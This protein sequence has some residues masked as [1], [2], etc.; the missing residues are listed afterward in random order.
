[1]VGVFSSSA[2]PDEESDGILTVTSP[3]PRSTFMVI[4]ENTLYLVLLW[5]CFKALVFFLQIT[6]PSP[7]TQSRKPQFKDPFLCEVEEVEEIEDAMSIPSNKMAPSPMKIAENKVP[8]SPTSVKKKISQSPDSVKKHVSRSSTDGTGKNVPESPRV[9][10]T[11]SV[12]SAT[13]SVGDPVQTPTPTRRVVKKKS[14]STPDPTKDQASDSP[15][16]V[17]K[18]ASVSP[19]PDL[20]KPEL[21]KVS[22]SE[23]AKKVQNTTESATDPANKIIKKKKITSAPDVA[24]NDKADAPAINKP[25]LPKAPVENPDLPEVPADKPNLPVNTNKLDEVKGKADETGEAPKKILK[26]K[27]KRVPPPTDDKLEIPNAKTLNAPEV[28]DASLDTSDSPAKARDEI[29]GAKQQA[30]QATETPKKVIKKRKKIVPPTEDKPDISEAKGADAPNIPEAPTDTPDLPVNTTD[31]SERS[32]DD[33]KQQA[34]NTGGALD[35]IPK[36]KKIVPQNNENEPNLSNSPDLK[37]SEVPEA[38]TEKPNVPG[39]S[40]LEKQ[41]D[42]KIPKVENPEQLHETKENVTGSLDSVKHIAKEDEGVS[43]HTPGSE[44]KELDPL[45]E[46]D[47]EEHDE[48]ESGEE[49]VN[50]SLKEYSSAGK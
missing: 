4:I 22:K 37:T 40:D 29:D 36:K 46:P 13:P 49:E 12:Q 16:K 44:L 45:P 17:P 25:D 38:S 28:P 19:S 47:S 43:S 15:K 6:N 33:L 2:L 10:K 42:T 11:P 23:Q 20:E 50:N 35:K 41:N 48:E 21:S 27:K 31:K 1:M 18:K 3:V 14:T 7:L 26:K 34:S 8:K 24:K 32:V 9:S 30:N 5:Y 39:T